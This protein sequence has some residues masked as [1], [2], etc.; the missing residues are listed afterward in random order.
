MTTILIASLFLAIAVVTFTSLADSILR[1]VRAYK[2]L[3]AE[4]DGGFS[5][6]ASPTAQKSAICRTRASQAV[7]RVSRGASIGSLPLPVAA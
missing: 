4:L 3:N 2:Q 1:G 6:A 7:R 5:V